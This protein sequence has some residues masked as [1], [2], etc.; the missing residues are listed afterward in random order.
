LAYE[1]IECFGMALVVQG[2]VGSARWSKKWAAKNAKGRCKCGQ[3]TNFG[4]FRSQRSVR[5][6]TEKFNMNRETVDLWMRKISTEMVPQILTDDQKQ[7]QL[8][9]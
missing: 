1:E 2:K 3:G 5:L 9:G 8:P 6:I 7:C 4:A